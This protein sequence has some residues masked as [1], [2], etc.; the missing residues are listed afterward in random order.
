MSE[1]KRK[2]YITISV[3]VLA[4][5]TIFAFTTRLWV[6]TSI[7]IGFLFGFFLQKGDLCGSS[8][9]SEVLLMKDW[10]KIWGLWVCIVISM[11]GFAVLDLVGWVNLNPKPLIW[12]NYVIGGVLFG[13]GMV[14]AGGC[15]SGCLFKAGIGNLNSM[16]A[17]LGI[18]LGVSLVEHGPLHSAN[19][20]LKTFVINTSDGG[21]VTLSSLTGF[22]FWIWT[23]FFAVVTIAIAFALRRKPIQAEKPFSLKKKILV[24]SWKPWQAGLMIGLLGSVAYLSSAASGRNY[25]LGVTHGVMHLKLLITDSNL[26]HVYKKKSTPIKDMIK[27]VAKAKEQEHSAKA[28][29]AKPPGKKVSWWLI[30]LVTSLVLGSW[31]SGRLSGEARLLPKP[32]EQIVIAFFGSLLVGIG[33]AFAVGCVIGNIISG[34]ALM[35]IG[36][37]LFGVVVILSNWVTT[38]FYLM[39]GSLH[40][41]E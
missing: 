5:I 2:S 38:Y 25:P 14:L 16:V 8:A 9:F 11:A 19:T 33:A 30:A 12:A 10:R 3:I 20:Y 27:A 13:V 7:P 29:T 41:T 28:F 22:P 17:L 32:P 21:R 35:S 6:L 31:V 26:N 23:L 36:T 40:K 1:R 34:W 4:L 39:G 15:V 18:A 24:R 37:L